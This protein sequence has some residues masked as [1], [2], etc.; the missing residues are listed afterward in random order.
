MVKH[1]IFDL[2]GVLINLNTQATIDAFTHLGVSIKLDA[3]Q[4]NAFETGELTEAEFYDF[5]RASQ[6]PN[7]SSV[8]PTTQITTQPTNQIT[9]QS[10]IQSTTQN[11]NQL[12][13][14]PLSNST[15]DAAWNKML[16]DF[17]NNRLELLMKLKQAKINLYLLSNTNIIHH[18]CFEQ[19]LLRQWNTHNFNGIMQGV[20]YSYQMGLRKPNPEIYNAVLQA[21][22]LPPT[23]TLFIDDNQQNILGAQQVGLTT[24]WLQPGQCITE[25]GLDKV[26]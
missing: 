19:T 4:L 9:T 10:A 3:P 6:T 2:G 1:I 7:Q 17:P 23:E 14:Q 24:I 16:L 20:Y 13:D 15:I 22:S 5:I 8:Q 21:N 18:R 25:L 12:L 11:S 26:Q